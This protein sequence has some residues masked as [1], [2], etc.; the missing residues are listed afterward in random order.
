MPT[1]YSGVPCA[2]DPSYFKGKK[3]RIFIL[4]F[5]SF[6]S[7]ILYGMSHW[8]E[9]SLRSIFFLPFFSL[10]LSRE[11]LYVLYR[12]WLN[13]YD[14][15]TVCHENNKQMEAQS[16]HRSKTWATIAIINSDASKANAWQAA[17]AP[18]TKKTDNKPSLRLFDFLKCLNVTVKSVSFP[19]R[20]QN[21][22]T[23][24]SQSSVIS[25]S[26]VFAHSTD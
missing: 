24:D 25:I 21:S 10:F 11:L 23:V 4:R 18:R 3:S 8:M 20:T 12:K 19:F 14:F 1:L 5:F 22:L 7:L 2:F 9:C 13:D 6:F 17:T 26:A 16:K 15:S